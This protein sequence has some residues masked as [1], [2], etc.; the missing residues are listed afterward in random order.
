LEGEGVCS[1][2]AMSVLLIWDLRTAWIYGR[3]LHED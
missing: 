2:P 3:H 1:A